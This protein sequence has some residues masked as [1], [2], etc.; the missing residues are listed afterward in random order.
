MS[1]SGDLG[2]QGDVKGKDGIEFAGEV[3]VEINKRVFLTTSMRED[4]GRS[5]SEPACIVSKLA[6]YRFLYP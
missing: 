4:T 5:C 3:P 6:F 2:D 1:A